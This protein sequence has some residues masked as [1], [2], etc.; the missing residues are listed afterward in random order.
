MTALLERERSGK[1]QWVQSSLL[2]AGITLTDFQAARYL[3][4]A[5]PTMASQQ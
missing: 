4:K 3:K 2:Q 1:G 5:L